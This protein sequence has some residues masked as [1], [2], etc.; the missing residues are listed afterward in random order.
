MTCGVATVQ[1]D[2][3]V[4]SFS[5]TD[6]VENSVELSIADVRDGFRITVV[7]F[8]GVTIH[9]AQGFDGPPAQSFRMVAIINCAV[10]GVVD[11]DIVTVTYT[12]IRRESK[13][14]INY[15]GTNG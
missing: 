6:F 13:K 5:A 12:G 7:G 3:N 14:C 9:G 8:G 10:S 4:M 15:V 11:D 2:R 1:Y